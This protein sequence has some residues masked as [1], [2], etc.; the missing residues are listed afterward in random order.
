MGFVRCAGRL[1][2]GNPS[3]K[4]IIIMRNGK[5]FSRFFVRCALDRLQAIWEMRR[6]KTGFALFADSTL[7]VGH[8]LAAD[9]FDDLFQP[10]DFRG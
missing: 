1:K 5:I 8:A 10:F 4:L 3:P 2:Q 6:K 7:V 9:G